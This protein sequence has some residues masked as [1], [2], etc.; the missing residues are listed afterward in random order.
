MCFH[1]TVLVEEAGKGI[2]QQSA[3]L[4]SRALIHEG[5]DVPSWWAWFTRFTEALLSATDAA[6]N[7]GH[8]GR[9]ED[10]QESDLEESCTR[11][12]SER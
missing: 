11:V 3:L 1:A 7:Y 2:M 6:T 10:L 12:S 9:K 5:D 4:V 8:E